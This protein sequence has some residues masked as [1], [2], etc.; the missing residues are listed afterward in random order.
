MEDLR[1]NLESTSIYNCDHV[2][3][4][5]ILNAL[6]RAINASSSNITLIC[7]EEISPDFIRS[8]LNLSKVKSIILPKKIDSVINE[9]ANWVGYYRDD[10]FTIIPP[11]KIEREIIYIGPSSGFGV[12]AALLVIMRG[13]RKITFCINP[14]SSLKRNL[15]SVLFSRA[16]S[17]AIFR[18]NQMLQT[19]AIDYKY[20]NFL[21]KIQI[22]FIEKKIS[23]SLDRLFTYISSQI[24]L[25]KKTGGIIFVGAGLGPG[26]AE[27]QLV[28]TLFGLKLQGVGGL[29][30]LHYWPMKA[31]NNFY[32]QKLVDNK[33]PY[34]QVRMAPLMTCNAL[35]EN[36]F[37]TLSSALGSV[38]DDVGYFVREFEERAPSIVHIW[39]D[40]MNIVAGLAALI[41]GVPKIILSC[42]SMAPD[43][44]LF[45]KPY[46]RPIYDF[47]SKF[48]NVH[49][50]ANS[51]AGAID[52]KRWLNSE[53]VSFKIIRN[54]FD[55]SLNPNKAS[56]SVLRDCYRN[57]VNIPKE[58]TVIGAVMR[59][60]EEKRPHL[61]IEVAKLILKKKPNAHFLIVGD[62]N[63]RKELECIISASS[64]QHH[65]HFVGVEKDVYPPLLAM[66]IF[67]L[68]SRIE[69][70]PNVLIEAQSVGLPVVTMDVGG[71]S[72]SLDEGR[73]GYALDTSD[74]S[75]IASVILSVLK[76]PQWLTRAKISAPLFVEENFSLQK[77][78]YETL[79]VYECDSKL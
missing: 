33:I 7:R 38:A 19:R 36:E 51:N 60:S 50:L 56:W 37:L 77:M 28:N 18:L 17:S 75:L 2:V 4:T 69:G 45:H 35:G 46:M 66:D 39:L 44:F 25:Y 13:G 34:S 48:E 49:F 14:F 32:L 70:L 30:F 11:K 71:A 68:T 54:G 62:G 61:W 9:G 24:H 26:G 22:R 8:I 1:I 31:P 40:E 65:F 64:L 53:D 3:E 20:A 73:T 16:A 6:Y 21:Y 76:N 58:A 23:I 52:Y 57:D 74:P 43:N 29:H 78:L 10:G 79:R 5:G 42:R 55:F 63:L 67:L 47:L 41:V 59:I 72:E 15:I 27:R 12:R